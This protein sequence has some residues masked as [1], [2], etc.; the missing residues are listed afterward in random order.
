MSGLMVT[1][2]REAGGMSGFRACGSGLHMEGLTGRIHITTITK[3]DGA[4]MKAIGTMR[5]MATIMTVTTTIMIMTT[6]TTMM[7]ITTT[8]EQ[9]KSR[10]KAR[11]ARKAAFAYCL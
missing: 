2:A 1:G 4:C 11:A 7:I 5:T 9:R 10:T 6:I 8:R 3:M